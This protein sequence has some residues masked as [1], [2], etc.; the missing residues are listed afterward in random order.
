MAAC[1]ATRGCDE[2][3]QSRCPHALAFDNC[4]ADCHYAACDRPTHEPTIDPMLILDETV[5]RTANVKDICAFCTFF[6][7]HGPRL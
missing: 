5:D 1:W 7:T 4:P 2:E 3:M 6:L